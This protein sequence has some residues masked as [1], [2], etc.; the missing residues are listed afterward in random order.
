MARAEDLGHPRTAKPAE[1]G[2]TTSVAERVLVA[3][4]TLVALAKEYADRRPK[5]HRSIGLQA[6]QKRGIGPEDPGT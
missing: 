6:N 5:K 2:M 3:L 4:V 1:L